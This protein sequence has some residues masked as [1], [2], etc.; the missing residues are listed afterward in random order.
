M[1]GEVEFFRKRFF[2]GF[3]RKDVV[4]YISKLSQERNDWR[5]AKEKAD[6]DIQ[7]LNNHIAVYELEI[8]KA[9]QEVREALEFKAVGIENAAAAFSQLGIDFEDLY[10]D[11]ETTT[12]SICTELDQAR[13]TVTA[14]PTLLGQTRNNINELQAACEAEKNA[15]ADAI[16][17]TAYYNSIHGNSGQTG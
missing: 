1:A 15:T 7:S 3:N 9:R 4:K 12:E 16:N 17:A 10:S 11:L 2:G 8:K 6:Q 13:R 5:E 14:L